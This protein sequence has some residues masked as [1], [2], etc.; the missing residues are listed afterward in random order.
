MVPR[1]VRRDVPPDDHGFIPWND[2]WNETFGT[3]FPLLL[4]ADF[5]FPE[6]AALFIVMAV[7]I[8][9]IARSARKAP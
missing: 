3:D 7:V 9:L 6:A 8:G 2:I 4:S 5:Y 1:P